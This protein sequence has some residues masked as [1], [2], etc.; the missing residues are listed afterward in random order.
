MA[1]VLYSSG[2]NDECFTPDYGV[3]PI[4]QYIPPGAVVWCPFDTEESLFVQKIRARGHTVIRSH[5]S[6]GKDFLTWSPPPMS[7]GT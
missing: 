4:L 6:E 2:N 5:I 7:T 3:E 1:N